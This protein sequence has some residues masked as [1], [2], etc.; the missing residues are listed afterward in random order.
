MGRFW[1]PILTHPSRTSCLHD[2]FH[3]RNHI[4]ILR[5][6]ECNA[7]ISGTDGM[8]SLCDHT[9]RNGHHQIICPV[10]R[11]I[12]GFPLVRHVLESAM[13]AG[14]LTAFNIQIN[15]NSLTAGGDIK[16]CPR[17]HCYCSRDRVN[18]N[19]VPCAFCMRRNGRRT[20]FCWICLGTWHCNG[21]TCGNAACVLVDYRLGILATCGTRSIG[22]VTGVPNTRGC[23]QCGALIQHIMGCNHMTCVCGHEFCFIC[24]QPRNASGYRC[25]AYDHCRVAP[26]QTHLPERRYWWSHQWSPFWLTTHAMA[27]LPMPPV[28]RQLNC[29]GQ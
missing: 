2:T 20:S 8:R 9:T 10:C 28:T 19:R 27:R 11:A 4:P 1:S 22:T 13:T 16:Q 12:W 23:A 5:C 25:W 29:N 6:E 3:I 24:L 15:A 18:R 14:E 7:C 17:C 26:R 21:S